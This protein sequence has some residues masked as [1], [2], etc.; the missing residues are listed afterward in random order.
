MNKKVAPSRGFWKAASGIL[1]VLLIQAC[2]V[3]PDTPES[4]RKSGVEDDILDERDAALAQPYIDP[5]T[6]FIKRYENRGSLEAV[7]DGVRK[8]REKRCQEVYEIY[9]ERAANTENLGRLKRNYNYS[10]PAMVAAYIREWQ[11]QQKRESR[12]GEDGADRCH[13]A[14]LKGNALTTLGR[15]SEMGVGGNPDAQYYLASSHRKLRQYEE[16]VFWAEKAAQQDHVD[17]QFLLGDLYAAGRGTEQD[18]QRALLWKKQAAS[19][20]HLNAQLDVAQSFLLGT[21]TSPSPRMAR[22]WYQAAAEKGSVL[23]QLQ[24][25][26]LYRSGQLGEVDFDAAI[27]WYKAA[28]RQ[29]DSRALYN[30]GKIHAN[31]GYAGGNDADAYLWFKLAELANYPFAENALQALREAIPPGRAEKLD[32]RARD[33]ISSR[34]F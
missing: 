31:P 21:G 30:L 23:A 10:C 14:F 33:L 29:G 28:A 6:D 22:F 26:D 1:A 20:G 19:Q 16:S 17:A 2:S 4:S 9:Q 8:E 7:V 25:G 5:L 18:P 27:E 13:R 24:L 32:G 12:G 3:T 11:Q 15:C 34:Q